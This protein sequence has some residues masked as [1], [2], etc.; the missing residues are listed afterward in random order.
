M[1][2]QDEDLRYRRQQVSITA[3]P[4]APITTPTQTRT[5]SPIVPVANQDAIRVAYANALF[6]FV[7]PV[8]QGTLRATYGIQSAGRDTNTGLPSVSPSAPRIRNY[9][10]GKERASQAQTALEAARVAAGG[11]QTDSGYAFLNQAIN[12]MS[13]LGA[14]G[15]EEG[16]SRGAYNEFTSRFNELM[17]QAKTNNVPAFYQQMAQMFVQPTFS[18]GKLMETDKYGFGS[19]SR[20]LFT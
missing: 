17:E 4:P 11:S 12:L 15:E 20:R 1:A 6:P 5:L 16:M 13:T 3:P 19:A 14:A 7:A 18:S 9:F 10:L 8:D 2:K